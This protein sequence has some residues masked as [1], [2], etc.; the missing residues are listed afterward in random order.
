MKTLN[1]E[2]FV[3]EL[4]TIYSWR[5]VAERTEKVYD[6]VMEKPC[7]SILTRLESSLAWGPVVGVWALLFCVLEMIVLV[8]IDIVWPAEQID[9]VQSFDSKQYNLH[10]QDYGEHDAVLNSGDIFGVKS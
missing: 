9:I 6:Y 3:D 5:Q 2:N 10:P 1:C 4:S 7:P 8:I